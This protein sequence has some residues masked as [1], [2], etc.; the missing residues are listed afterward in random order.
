MCNFDSN[1]IPCCRDIQHYRSHNRYLHDSPGG[2]AAA[3]H[4]H[5]F[6]SS[7]F[8]SKL[9][10]SD[11]RSRHVYH[12]GQHRSMPHYHYNSHHYMNSDAVNEEEVPVKR[13]RL[14]M[15]VTGKALNRVDQLNSTDS[16][17]SSPGGGEMGNMDSPG[18]ASPTVSKKEEGASLI[19][20]SSCEIDYWSIH[21][22]V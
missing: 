11:S 14:M 17:N 22:H 2:L 7:A 5:S 6:P 9:S 3:E 15:D 8:H 18:I 20:L 12:H 10:K 21:I 13:P 16:L 1:F 19:A 4:P